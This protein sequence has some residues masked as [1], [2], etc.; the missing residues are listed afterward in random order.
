VGNGLGNGLGMGFGVGKHERTV[1][2]VVVVDE[3]GGAEVD[4]GAALQGGEEGGR[5]VGSHPAGHPVQLLTRHH[6]ALVLHPWLFLF[7][8]F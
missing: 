2:V 8:L 3:V 4:A 7:S 5:H 1:I 6:A